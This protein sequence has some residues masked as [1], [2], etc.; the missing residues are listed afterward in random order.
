MPNMTIAYCPPNIIRSV[1]ACY[2][3]KDSQNYYSA[4]PKISFAWWTPLDMLLVAQGMFYL[5]WKSCQFCPSHGAA[6][7][8]QTQ[9]R[10]FRGTFR[11]WQPLFS[12]HDQR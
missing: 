7:L 3:G 11:L 5:F 1:T 12:R 9:S 2:H 8:D 10:I 6:N 4:S